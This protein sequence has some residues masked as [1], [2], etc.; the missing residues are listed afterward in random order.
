MSS[1]ILFPLLF[2][3]SWVLTYAVKEIAI[4]KALV[5]IP[6]DRSSHVVPT[7]HGGGIAI[8]VTWFSGIGYLYMVDQIDSGLF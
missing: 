5:D 7:P 6:N 2:L 4:K 8:A 1:F 3:L